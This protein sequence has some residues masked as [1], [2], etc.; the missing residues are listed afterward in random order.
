MNLQD[1]ANRLYRA[2]EVIAPELEPQPPAEIVKLKER[3]PGIFDVFLVDD[4]FLAS[5]HDVTVRHVLGSQIGT[6]TH[7]AQVPAP[8]RESANGSGATGPS[9]APV[10][11]PRKHPRK[12]AG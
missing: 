5:I 10:R 6:I 12:T 8:A 7:Q 1:A 3:V 4:D 2:I 11:R 9:A